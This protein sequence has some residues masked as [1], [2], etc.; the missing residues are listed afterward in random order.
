MDLQYTSMRPESP[1]YSVF[2]LSKMGDAVRKILF[3]MSDTGGG[4][5]AAC[6]AIIAA[7]EERYQGQFQTELV[8]MWRDY[9][10]Y[11][12]NTMPTTYGKWVNLHP[13]SYEAQYWI[14][15]RVFQNRLASGVMERNMYPRL[16]YLYRRHPA[17]IVVCVHSVFV[18]PALYARR[19]LRVN[20]PFVTVITDYALPPVLWY[21]ARA[22][23]TLVPTQPAL[24]RGLELGLSSAN[25]VLTGPVIHPRFTKVTLSKAEARAKLGW[26]PNARIVL[27]VGGGDGMGPLLE[28]AKAID[29]N[30]SNAHLVAVAGKNTVLKEA[31]EA[32]SWRKPTMIFGFTSEMEI[33][34]RAADVLVS[35]AGPA[36]I[37]EAAMLGTPMILSG[38]IKYQESPNADYVVEQGAGLYAPGAQPVAAALEAVFGTPGR[39]EALEAAARK[40]AAPDA[41]YRIADEIWNTIRQPYLP[42]TISNSWA[43]R[44]P[45]E[46]AP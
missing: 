27:L 5:R 35:K 19:K 36:T 30:Q 16:K 45:L 44:S 11:P 14:N 4:H 24:K 39:L 32:V 33:M 8:D 34:M 1:L 3:L 38:A 9:T 40:L 37:T 13:S 43:T 31:L 23:K 26:E 22:D 41:V 18:R 28:T 42:S 15:D 25:L 6:R 46:N 12:F 7:L 20:T 10:P 17:D 2:K 29:A 21:D